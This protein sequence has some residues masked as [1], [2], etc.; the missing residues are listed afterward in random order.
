[1]ALALRASSLPLAVSVARLRE[2]V[3]KE[4][5]AFSLLFM[6]LC[7]QH[8]EQNWVDDHIVAAWQALLEQGRFVVMEL[9]LGDELIAADFCHLGDAGWV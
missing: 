7:V 8:S 3:S 6:L 2:Q 1:M 5:S 4:E 9:F